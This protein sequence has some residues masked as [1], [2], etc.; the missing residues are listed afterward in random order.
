MSREDRRALISLLATTI[1]ATRI[2]HAR[3]RKAI[4]VI[5]RRTADHNESRRASTHRNVGPQRIARC[6]VAGRRNRWD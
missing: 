1:G 5:H 3:V 4:V 2:I 6:A